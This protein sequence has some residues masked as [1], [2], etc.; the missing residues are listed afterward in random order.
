[1]RCT[2]QVLNCTMKGCNTLKQRNIL[3]KK[4]AANGNKDILLFLVE[5]VANKL[6]TLTWYLKNTL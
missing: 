2:V 6:V 3:L 4:R 5:K 1:M